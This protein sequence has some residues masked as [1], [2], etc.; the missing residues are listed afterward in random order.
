[1]DR[2]TVNDAAPREGV[3][4]RTLLRR[5][6]AY[7]SFVLLALAA[8]GMIRVA[9]SGEIEAERATYLSESRNA[10]REVARNVEH[11]LTE[12]YQGLRTIARLPGVRDI[13]R[14]GVR[15]EPSSR[16]AVQELYNNLASEVALSEVYIEI[17]RAHV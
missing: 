15:F 16:Q 14:Y 9:A 2:V 11:T 1:M 17:G 7:G 10:S 3:S 12:I 4:G 8:E 13:D 6:F 5:A